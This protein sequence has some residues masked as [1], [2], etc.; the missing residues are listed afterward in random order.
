MARNVT[1]RAVAFVS[2]FVL[3]GGA[4]V[5]AQPKPSGSPWFSLTEEFYGDGGS[6]A[7]ALWGQ[8]LFNGVMFHPPL[9]SGEQQFLLNHPN[10]SFIYFAIPPKANVASCYPSSTDTDADVASILTTYAAQRGGLSA[11]VWRL[12]MPEFD[13]SG[14][15]WV[16]GRPNLAGLSDSE[17]YTTWT[18]FYLDTLHLGTHLNQTTQQ[19]GYKWMTVANYAF[20]AQYAYDMGSDIVLLERCIDEMSGITPGLAMIRGAANQHGGKDWG[21]DISSWR[22]WNDGPTQYHKGKLIRGWSSSTVKRHLF[23]AYMG[24]A[25]VLN[26]EAPDYINGP[27]SRQKLNPQGLAVQSFYNFA[28]TRHPNRGMPY[29]PMAIMQDHYSGFEPKFGEFAQG[30]FKWYY[31]AYSQNDRMFANLLG[32]IYPNYNLWGTLPSGSPKVLIPDGSIN[33]SATMTAYQQALASG[34]DPRQWEP[35]GSSRW[36]ETFDI[37]TNQSPLEALLKY[38]AIVLATGGP[39]SDALLGTLS[40]YVQQGGVLSS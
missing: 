4:E 25:N 21:I 6:F 11:K 5:Q 35:M 20:G 1:G 26:M 17:A 29:V 19:R 36:G 30:D 10:A 12:A 34:V 28:V 8:R 37:L 38:K 3:N 16:T 39:M 13:Q 27:A 23:L 31:N 22:Y 24:G 7:Q 14:G 15:C 18:G 40:Q 9:K 33:V 2:L 32:L